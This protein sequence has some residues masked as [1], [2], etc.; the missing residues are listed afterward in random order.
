MGEVM[1][2]SMTVFEKDFQTREGD[3]SLDSFDEIQNISASGAQRL[4]EG[5]GMALRWNIFLLRTPAL[6]NYTMQCE[7]ARG[8]EQAGGM[9]FHVHIRYDEKSN[10]S[11]VLD[12]TCTSNTWTGRIGVL[13]DHKITFAG[14]AVIWG[15][16]DCLAWELDVQDEF[17]MFAGQRFQ[18]PQG[19]PKEGRIGFS[20]QFMDQQVTDY[21]YEFTTLKKVKVTSSPQKYALVFDRKSWELPQ[22]VFAPMSSWFFSLK[23]YSMENV[24]CLNAAIE[25]GPVNC[26]NYGTFYTQH[27]GNEYIENPYFQIVHS[28]GEVEPKQYIYYGKIGFHEHWASRQ[29]AI[30]AADVEC[31]VR[32]YFYL[33]ELPSDCRIILG[34]EKM[35]S[36][37]RQSLSECGREMIVDPFSGRLLGAHRMD[38]GEFHIFV[39]S[40]ADKDICRMI[41]KNV[42]DYENALRFAESNHFFFED[43]AC[44]FEIVGELPADYCSTE[45]LSLRI[46]LENVFKEPLERKPEITILK[47][48]APA[49]PNTMRIRYSCRFGKLP[50]GVY[51]LRTELLMNGEILAVERTAFESMS[52]QANALSASELSGLPTVFSAHTDFESDTNTFDPRGEGSNN[53]AHYISI[54]AM[55]ALFIEKKRE[56]ELVKLYGRRLFSW[57]YE[58]SVKDPDVMQHLESARNSEYVASQVLRDYAPVNQLE[59]YGEK[60]R[61]FL[62]EFLKSKGDDVLAEEAMNMGKALSLEYLEKLLAKYGC[63][64]PAYAA[65]ADHDEREEIIRKWTAAGVD[66]KSYC[67]YSFA[68]FYTTHTGTTFTALRYGNDL[69][70]SKHPQYSAFSLAEDYPYLCSYPTI[71]A[72]FMISSLK[73][74]V[75][76]MNLWPEIYG[77]V[78]IPIDWS[79]LANHLP[80]GAM[81]SEV[82]AKK[83][84][85]FKC[86][87]CWFRDGEFHF[88]KDDGFQ[89]RN[90]TEKDFNILIDTW[91]EIR[92]WKPMKVLRSMAIVGGSECILKHKPVAEIKSFPLT[93][94]Y[95][96]FYNTA[97][98]F[99]A[100]VTMSSR[101]CGLPNGFTVRSEEI[102]RL[103]PEDVSTLVLPP[104]DCFSEEEKDAIRKLFDAGVNIF[105]AELADGMEDLFGVKKRAPHPVREIGNETTN[106]INNPVLWEPEEGVEVLL[107]DRENI[108]L[109]TLKKGKSGAFAVFF[110]FAPTAFLRRK[111]TA[112]AASSK[113]L[114]KAIDEVFRCIE[115]DAAEVTISK[116]R[117]DAFRDAS[118]DLVVIAMEDAHPLPKKAITPLLTLKGDFRACRLESD[119]R[120]CLL[121][122]TEEKTLIRLHL[123]PDEARYFQFK[124]V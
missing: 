82:Y 83:F 89:L 91:K 44:A 75:P 67:N 18:L 99:P 70:N 51:H 94:D 93:G 25:G 59:F 22:Q 97:E 95:L 121:E 114:A 69:R 108:P 48:D 76:D 113:V 39:D 37:D 90:P 31:P 34:F 4:A 58:R 45:E 7:M 47:A 16:E 77:I 8:P 118:G 100:F 9:R 23:A 17:C 40:G 11:G 12:L 84:Y 52:R 66:P 43:E 104:M 6:K 19:V 117:I 28:D 98:D 71:C 49:F 86:R 41:P 21:K 46:S 65:K 54:S 55:Q 96:D 50:A 123:E 61:K 53:C 119:A 3:S 107:R 111:I 112:V 64:W 120:Y 63:E 10:V 26:P 72:S 27:L 57:Y 74:D 24:V 102:C 42:V 29:P 35:R 81:D 122:Q 92:K 115:T 68:P 88:W 60:H 13:K 14:P 78:G 5:F 30:P 110:T 73:L 38:H 15:D 33:K 101:L 20:H 103:K 116:G 32:Q 2:D 105:C 124:K 62:A 79:T 109:L 80:D 87:S 56:W 1:F 36:E 85:D 106:A